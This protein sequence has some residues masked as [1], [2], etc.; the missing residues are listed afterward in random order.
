MPAVVEKD[1]WVAWIL[2]RLFEKPDLAQLLMFKGGTS[3]SKVYNL[4][5]RFSE[6]IDLVL[7]WNVL[8]G[9]DPLAERSKTKQH[10]L[11]EAIN[12]QAQTYIGGKL[13]GMINY[14]LNGICGCRVNDDPFTI[15]INY[16]S[17]FADD[18]LRSEVRL[19]IGLL[20]SW[21]P[22]EERCI[23]CYAAEAF[24]D[25]FE[26][27]EC[28]VK[29]IKAE[30]TFWEKATILHHEAH[31]PK[32]NVQPARYSRHYYD[33]ARMAQSPVKKKALADPELLASMVAFKQRF[34][35][36]G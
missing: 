13:L 8:N 31:R 22:Y 16:P 17:A 35:H 15:N 34:Y 11:N 1:F 9:E 25:M 21:Q 10:K 20:A 36:R 24:P 29:V 19:E 23:T 14:A 26:Q 32:G 28:M 3:L 6:D 12:K 27:Q 5:E 18:F 2:N 4:I 33:L 7:N 30:R